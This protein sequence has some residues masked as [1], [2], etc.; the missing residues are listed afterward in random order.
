MTFRNLES[1]MDFFGF[2]DLLRGGRV[3]GKAPVLLRCPPGAS[4]SGAA[5]LPAA[6][7]LGSSRA[8]ASAFHLQGAAGGGRLAQGALQVAA[9]AA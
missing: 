8:G 4:G 9:S 3:S 6:R 7:L 2:I 1:G 5:L